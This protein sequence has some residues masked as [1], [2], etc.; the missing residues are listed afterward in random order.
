MTALED[1]QNYV[2]GVQLSIRAAH[3]TKKERSPSAIL[4]HS[5]HCITAPSCHPQL[6]TTPSNKKEKCFKY[7]DLS[8]VKQ[9]PWS[10][11]SGGV[12]CNFSLPEIEMCEVEI[13]PYTTQEANFTYV[14]LS[15]MV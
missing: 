7:Q 3:K 2:K 10:D 5:S 12:F 15:V 1:R 8:N 6:T 9:R 11:G 13:T 14:L 4:I